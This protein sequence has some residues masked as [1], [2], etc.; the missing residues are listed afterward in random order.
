[1]RQKSHSPGPSTSDNQIPNMITK[2]HASTYYPNLDGWRGYAI[3]WIMLGHVA[4]VYSINYADNL[5]LLFASISTPLAVDIFFIISGYM[6]A[7]SLSVQN[8]VDLKTFFRKRALRILPIYFFTVF[9]VFIV[10]GF[11]PNYELKVDTK[12][13]A[14]TLSYSDIGRNLCSIRS[15]VLPAVEQSY[16]V[17]TKNQAESFWQNLFLVQN[18]YP[19]TERVK[20]L[21]HT[22]FVAIIFHFYIIYGLLTLL[23]TKLFHGPDTQRNVMLC[24]LVMLVLSIALLRAEFGKQYYEYFQ[25]TH[26]RLDAILLGSVLNLSKGFLSSMHKK[27][28]WNIITASLFFCTGLVILVTL[29][30][31]WPPTD[32]NQSPNSFT[33]S[34]LAFGLMII[35][36]MEGNR[37]S[38]IVFGNP[39]IAW[40]GNYSY[41]IYLWHYPFMFFYRLL[42]IRMQWSNLFSITTFCILSI[43]IGAGLQR[44]FENVPRLSISVIARSSH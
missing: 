17:T 11:A 21:A 3:L 38:R 1:M 39:V 36:T 37:F 26:F 41:G 24:L 6:I 9:C 32:W 33:L 5:L 14:Q 15:D 35:P 31:R 22:W 12:L 13:P 40:I 7:G 16:F 20:L 18:F 4:Y 10:D 28:S 43:A 25:M 30:F 23:I 8:Q 44:L 42:A 2:A 29:I 34:Y 19:F 27:I